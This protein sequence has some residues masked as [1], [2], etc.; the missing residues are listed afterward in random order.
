M[1]LKSKY[2]YFLY[3]DDQE[4]K[5]PVRVDKKNKCFLMKEKHFATEVAAYSEEQMYVNFEQRLYE[6]LIHYHIKGWLWKILPEY[7]PGFRA[8]ICRLV[9]IPR[10][11]KKLRK[12]PAQ[13]FQEVEDYEG[14][15]S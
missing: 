11:K 8:E 15:V 2:E 5:L 4:F 3:V 9:A 6:A 12:L 10:R 14:N 7:D 13:I 1:R